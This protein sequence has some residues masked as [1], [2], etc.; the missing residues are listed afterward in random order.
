MHHDELIGILDDENRLA[1]EALRD[2]SGEAFAVPTRLPLW[3]VKELVAHM[4]RDVDRIRVYLAEPEPAE[5]QADGVSYWRA[6]DPA[7]DSADVADR[8]K[9][10]ADGFATGTALVDSFE[11]NRIEV[12]ATAREVAADQLVATWGPA[13]RFD[14]YLRTRVL[15]MAVHGLDLADALGARPWLTPGGAA[16][17]R[18]ILI[19][20]LGEA[21]ALVR[22]WDD[23]TFIETGTGRRALSYEERTALGPLARMFPLLA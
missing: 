15:E 7:T 6:Y 22:R 1:V 2:L 11:A 14:E 3:N 23:R 13:M 16:V 10:V 12:L 20:L 4:W 5:A 21:P 19:G 9:E 18:D 8:A 17:T